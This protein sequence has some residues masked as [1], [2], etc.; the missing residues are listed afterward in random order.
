MIEFNFHFLQTLQNFYS[1]IVILKII[2]SCAQAGWSKNNL[3]AE[4]NCP[5]NLRVGI[6]HCSPPPPSR[7]FQKFKYIRL[8]HFGIFLTVLKT[9]IY[10]NK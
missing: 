3:E 2:L 8:S 5:N 10:I 6:G 9:M 4:E 7:F 1:G